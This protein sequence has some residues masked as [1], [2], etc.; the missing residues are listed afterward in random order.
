MVPSSPKMLRTI[1]L[2]KVGNFF[3]KSLL[4]GFDCVLFIM[5][6]KREITSIL[7]AVLIINFRFKRVDRKM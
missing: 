2:A 5:I 7:M 1:I 3:E 6:E 4:L